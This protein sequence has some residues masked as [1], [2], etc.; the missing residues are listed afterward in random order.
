[1]RVLTS[2]PSRHRRM[3]WQGTGAARHLDPH[4]SAVR[5][6][7][8]CR[9]SG[10]GG[11]LMLEV[12]NLEVHFPITKGI[13]LDRVVGFVRAVDGVD[14]D[15]PTGSTLGLVG[16]SGCGKSTVGKAI[17]R[18]VPITAGTV[19]FSDVGLSA[20]EGEDLRQARRHVQMIFQDPFSS[21]DP[22]QSVR[23]ILAEAIVTHKLRTGPAIDARV[24]E[25]LDAV[26]LPRTVAGRYPH[27]FSGG[28]RQRI[29]IARALAAEPALII[30]D[31]P[32][33]ALDVSIQ[34]QII[35]LLSDLQA[36]LGL[37]Y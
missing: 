6:P 25:L 16:E 34:A 24:K 29:G 15:I 37:T 12:R 21:L 1:M 31:E 4:A 5:Q 27:E 13:F 19:R 20:L 22:R 23:N 35:N 14:L 18:L 3:P 36:Q 11:R 28:Q 17:L 10:L 30:A 8:A 2:V 32:V 7:G 9:R 33:S 26:G